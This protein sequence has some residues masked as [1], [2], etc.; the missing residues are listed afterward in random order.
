[1]GETKPAHTLTLHFPPPE[2]GENTFVLSPPVCGVL[3]WQLERLRHT[4][5]KHPVCASAVMLAL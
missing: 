1:M 3:L 4:S 2:L 5:P